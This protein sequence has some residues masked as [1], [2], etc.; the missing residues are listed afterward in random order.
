MKN[1]YQLSTRFAEVLLNG[2]WIASTNFKDTLKQVTW[3]EATCKIGTL[4]TIAELTQHIG[5]YVS[6]LV[7]VFDGGNLEIRDK[8]SFDFLPVSSE[9]DW[10]KVLH[11]F[12]VN[13]EKFAAQVEQM[14]QRQLEEPF[15]DKKYGS[16]R[17]NIEAMIEHSYY[18]LG[19]ISLIKKLITQSN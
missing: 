18:H 10:Q 5:Y 8:Y 12:F 11:V 4:N 15:V 6:G 1:N 3:E 19:Q 7:Q 2:T 13:A 17:R 16:Y 9:E 14:T